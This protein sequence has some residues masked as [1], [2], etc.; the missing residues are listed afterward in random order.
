MV[1]PVR[2]SSGTRRTIWSRSG[3]Q[4]VA[5]RPIAASRSA[6]MGSTMEAK[7]GRKAAGWSPA[8]TKPAFGAHS[9]GRAAALQRGTE[10]HRSVA[11]GAGQHGVV[12]VL[13]PEPGLQVGLRGAVRHAGHHVFQAG[14]VGL[15][16]DDVERDG[17]GAEGLELAHDLGD[18]R[19]GPG[20][21]AERI[22]ALLVDRENAHRAR[23]IEGRRRDALER[24]E[25][26]V[27]QVVERRWLQPG[28]A[29]RDHDDQ[30]DGQLV[31]PVLPHRFDLRRP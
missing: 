12:A 18:A 2:T 25:D 27:A 11:E 10:H 6:G 13:G 9:V 26:E 29:D 30:R 20:P 28:H 31:G 16:E 8:T 17:R 23:R 15:C 22:Q 19:T 7:D 14:P 4:L 21:L 1:S 3:S 24:V 5:P